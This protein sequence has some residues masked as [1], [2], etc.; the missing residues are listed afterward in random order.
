MP[1]KKKASIVKIEK[2]HKSIDN[3]AKSLSKNKQILNAMINEA[4]LQVLISYHG[5]ESAKQAELKDFENARACAV[6]IFGKV[7][8]VEVW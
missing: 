2:V 4:T 8:G 5:V 6:R 3:M 1:K 7:F